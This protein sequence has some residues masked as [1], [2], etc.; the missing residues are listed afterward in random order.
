VIERLIAQQDV[1]DAA[2]QAHGADGDHDRRQV[3]ARHQD[4]VE[5]AAQQTHA[6]PDTTSSGVSIPAAAQKPITVELSAIVEA[7]DRSISGR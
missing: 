6:Q 1:G 3:K 7:T 4:T 5:Q 2:I